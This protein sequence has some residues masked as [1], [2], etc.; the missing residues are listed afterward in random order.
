MSRFLVLGATAIPDDYRID[1]LAAADAAPSTEVIVLS[2]AGRDEEI[3]RAH[4]A[5]A[6]TAIHGMRAP[7]LMGISQR[8]DKFPSPVQPR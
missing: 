6:P 2:V 7:A 3:N 1:D 5:T 8:R 4:E